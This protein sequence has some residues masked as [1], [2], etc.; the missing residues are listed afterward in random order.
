MLWEKGIRY[1]IEAIKILKQE[2]LN[3]EV[4]FVGEPDASNKTSV[5]LSFLEDCENQGLIKYLGF[6]DDI[7]KLLH[8]THVSILPTF[9][10]EGVP[11]SLI[12]AAS[13]GNAIITTDMPGCR[14]IVKDGLNGFIVPPKDAQ[15]IADAMK[16]II[17]NPDLAKSMGIE[18]RK[19]VEEMFSKEVVNKKTYE[20]YKATSNMVSTSPN[21]VPS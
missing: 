5:K 16:K 19:R 13:S 7:P 11:L 9:Y 10:R 6:R 12:E 21:V 4:W 17:K 8:E 14:E 20:V 2:N 3:F 18:G 15:S 1:L